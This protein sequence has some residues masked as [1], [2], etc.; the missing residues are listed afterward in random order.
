MGILNI[1]GHPCFNSAETG[2]VQLYHVSLLETL[3]RG[4]AVWFSW[5]LRSYLLSGWTLYGGNPESL[6]DMTSLKGGL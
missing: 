1:V 2:L 6:P 5:L 3:S 4:A